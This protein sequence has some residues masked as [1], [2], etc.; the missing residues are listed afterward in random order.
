M[1][2]LIG[3]IIIKKVSDSMKMNPDDWKR[4]NSRRLNMLNSTN[5]LDVALKGTNN[6]VQLDSVMIVHKDLK[7]NVPSRW[8]FV[9]RQTGKIYL[10]EIFCVNSKILGGDCECLSHEPID[11]KR[12][13]PEDLMKS[14]QSQ[15]DKTYGEN[16]TKILIDYVDGGT[17]W[18]INSMN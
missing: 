9:E 8:L 14:Y 7:I 12:L 2:L 18:L 16:F 6:R 1:N 3:I 11:R 15:L 4:L 13:T 17:D 10:D 5:N